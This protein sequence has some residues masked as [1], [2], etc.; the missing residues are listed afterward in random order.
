MNSNSQPSASDEVGNHGEDSR[1]SVAASSSAASV[2]HAGFRGTIG[3]ARCDITPPVKIYSRN[4]GAARHDVAESIHRPL[5]LSALTLSDGS[6]APPLVLIDADMGWWRTPSLFEAFQQRL[7]DEFSLQPQHL[8]FALTH[9]HAGPPLL[10]ADPALPL[11][12]VNEAWLNSVLEATVSTVHEALKNSDEGILEWHTGRCGLASNRDLVDP[13]PGSDRM[14]CG[15]APGNAADDTLL[16]GRITNADGS[17]RATIVNYACHPTTLAWENTAISPDYIGAMRETIES[18]TNAPA[19]FLLGACGEL[20][21][22][23]QYVGDPAV[24]DGHGRELGFA[25]LSTLTGMRPS[26]QNLSFSGAVE[27]GAPL[28]VWKHE[29]RTVSRELAAVHTEV[30]L[31]LKD[32]PSAAELEQQRLACTDRTLAERLLRKRDVRRRLGDGSTYALSLYVWRMGDAVIVGS[33]CEAYSLLQVEL[34]KRFPDNAI[35]C[36]N[37]M[38]G[39]L[40]YLPPRDLYDVDVYP[41]WQTPIDRGGLERV[42]D[43]LTQE[44]HDILQ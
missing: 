43:K 32:W 26:G 5:S 4:W 42:I 17:I 34:R 25:A 11:S 39:T 6:D 23:H 21:P 36:M 33:C 14:L 37:L 22:R 24:A 9:T 10:R 28:A 3:I 29:R 38:N 16:V 27:S 35:V 44:I 40:G 31:P 12:E 41:V 2:H 7:L 8:I 18:Q 15:Y 1:T 19:L 20:A 30:E 13:T